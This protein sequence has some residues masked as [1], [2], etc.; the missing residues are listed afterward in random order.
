M[1]SLKTF[2]WQILDYFR[3]LTGTIFLRVVF[4]EIESSGLQ[5]VKVRKEGIVLENLFGFF[6]TL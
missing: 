4:V 5:V 6:E 2:S 3:A 1:S